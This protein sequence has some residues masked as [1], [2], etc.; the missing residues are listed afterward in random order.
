MNKIV[1]VKSVK[2]QNSQNDFCVNLKNLSDK[3]L[4]LICKKWGAAALAARRKFAGLLPEIYAREMAE[5]EKGR[6][7]LKKRGFLS[8][9]EFAA[10]LA[11]MSREQV[12]LVLRLE[13]R[14]E[15][16]TILHSALVS[17][18]VSANKLARVVSIAT[19]ENQHDLLGKIE[20]LSSR[21]L[22]VFVKDFKNQN[23][24]TETKTGD[25]SLHVQTFKLEKNDLQ[26]QTL[27]SEIN[28]DLELA[29]DVKKNLLEMKK[30]GIDINQILRAFLNERKEKLEQEKSRI[31]EKQIQKRDDRAII[32]M[33]A[34]R[35]IPIEVR[36]VVIKEFGNKCSIPGCNRPAENLHHEKG[37]AIDQCHDPRYLK[38]LCRG[39]HE[40][41]HAGSFARAVIL[42]SLSIDAPKQK[43]LSRRNRMQIPHLPAAA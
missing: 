26:V 1:M 21:A 37:F 38:P 31:V 18:E 27:E 33:P 24:L 28:F 42:C 16:K 20:T 32:G 8:V 5:R 40:L 10:K 15:D 11:G 3:E 7:W 4:Y 23:G 9:Y 14:F 36:R 19:S 29:D 39:H 12:D 41:A 22:E 30:K 6:S 25:E 35:Y 34:N 43:C 13:K 17:G 2:S